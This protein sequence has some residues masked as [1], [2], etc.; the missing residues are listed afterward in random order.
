MS[1]RNDDHAYIMESA[2]EADRLDAKTDRE[3][4]ERQARWAGLRPGM[5]I[6]DV[7]CG[8]G[9]TT[10]LLFDAAAPGATAVGI[11]GSEERVGHARAVHGVPGI[12]YV[13]RDFYAGLDGLG[14][15][16]FVWCRFVLEYHRAASFDIARR[17]YDL[18]APGG[19]LCLVDLDHNCANHF[20]MPPRL[21]QA[22][23]A[24][25]QH[26]AEQGDF[27]P[28]LGRKLYSYLYDLGCEEIA[29]DLQAHHLIYGP[30]GDV[31][32]QNWTQKIDVALRE[33]GYPF[34]EY[35]DGF[36]GFRADWHRFFEDPRRF[37]YTPLIA[38]RGRKPRA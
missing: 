9:K 36:A 3:R 6:A 13:Q 28:W 5:R 30:L 26:V 29:V 34:P 1:T 22:F 4:L 25:L 27:D 14:S 17:L 24:A 11:D 33:S 18:V 31:D 12:E 23:A 8:S 16:D 10:R 7:G 15:F 35:E 21:E 32:R 19:I 38:V 37:T 2:T 20:G